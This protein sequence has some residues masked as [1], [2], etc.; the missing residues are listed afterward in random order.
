MRFMSREKCAVLLALA[1][2]ALGGLVGCGG[3]DDK[4]P[5]TAAGS[6]KAADGTPI[7]IRTIA[8]IGSP[9]TNYPDVQAAAGAAAKAINAAGGVNGRPIEW[10]FCN[11]RGEA[12]QAMKCA[13][14]AV[15]DKVAAVVGRVDIFAPQSTPILEKG[16]IPDIG[17]LPTGSPTDATSEI[18]YPLFGGNSGAY[19]AIAYAFAKDGRKKLITVSVD[20]PIAF[21]QIKPAQ[22]AAKDA[23]L[24]DLGIIKVPA[25]GVTDFSPYAQQVKDKGADAVLV[26]LGPAGSQAFVKAMDAV[27]AK[28]RLGT[29]V[30]SFGESEAQAIGHLADGYFVA[31]PFPSTNDTSNPAIKQFHEELDAAGVSKAADV[32]RVAGL[33]AW[34]AMHAVA[35]VAESIEGDVTAESLA[36]ALKSSGPIDLF[37]VMTWDPSKLGSPE[38]GSF[39]RFPPVDFNILTFDNGKLTETRIPVIK[40]PLRVSR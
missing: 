17:I 25:Q 40:D 9:L 29:T 5:A 38:Y 7:K 19:S 14:D 36:Q 28:A 22:K 23:G 33:N 35:K 20:L 37:G 10:S 2:V 6:S 16:G 3:G 15:R 27:G 12:N 34:F 24:Q 39:P 18:S 4:G 13:R 11:T 21:S 8:A 1:L 26:V 30:F 32:R 31:S